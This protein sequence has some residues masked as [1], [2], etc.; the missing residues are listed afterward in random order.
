MTWMPDFEKEA[1]CFVNWFVIYI[2][3]EKSLRTN[4]IFSIKVDEEGENEVKPIPS[5]DIN[6]QSGTDLLTSTSSLPITNELTHK[7]D[8]APSQAHDEIQSNK[9]IESKGK[10]NK[11][12]KTKSIRTTIEL[13]HCDIIKD[14]FWDARP[15]LLH[16]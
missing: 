11:N 4:L 1:F 8:G 7:E 2:Y 9:P 12:K 10:K 5:S 14:E 16:M 13:M 3:R 6:D 15:G